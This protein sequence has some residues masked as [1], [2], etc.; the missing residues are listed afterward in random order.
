MNFTKNF[1]SIAAVAFFAVV[2]F[3]PQQTLAQQT[4]EHILLIKMHVEPQ[5]AVYIKFADVD[6][7]CSVH[8]GRNVV[9]ENTRN[10]DKLIAIVKGGKLES[11]GVQPA[12]GKFKALN[13]SAAP[14]LPNLSCTTQNPPKCYT[15]PGGT[16]VCVCGPWLSAAAPGRN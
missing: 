9:G 13:P 7:E 11:F 12:R 6:G 16:C 15:L 1:V 2:F 3:A 10:G 8:E 4:R 14:C 5:A